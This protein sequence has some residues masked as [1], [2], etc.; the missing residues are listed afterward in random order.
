MLGAQRAVNAS[1][2]ASLSLAWRVCLHVLG[3]YLQVHDLA[4][5]PPP[6]PNASTSLYP[7]RHTHLILH[8]IQRGVS[9]SSSV[10]Q[11]P[12]ST[13]PSH[14]VCRVAQHQKRVAVAN[15]KQ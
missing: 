15:A 9:I 13:S 3:I 7:A 12:S 5:S 10:T 4:P 8:R 14:I 2:S 11:H 6:Q 1:V